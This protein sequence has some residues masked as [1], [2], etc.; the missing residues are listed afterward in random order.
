MYVL[1]SPVA[2]SSKK[3]VVPVAY[4]FITS[5]IRGAS[6]GEGEPLDLQLHVQVAHDPH[7]VVGG[8]GVAVRD[9]MISRRRLM[10]AWTEADA[11]T[12]LEFP[13]L[14]YTAA[15]TYTWKNVMAYRSNVGYGQDQVGVMLAVKQ[16]D[17]D[18]TDREMQEVQKSAKWLLSRP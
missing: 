3:R 14:P 15:P 17:K 1:P 16:Y 4:F 5:S 12:L 2:I 8:T 18:R 10:Y 6:S 13:P 9:D 7:P 11:G